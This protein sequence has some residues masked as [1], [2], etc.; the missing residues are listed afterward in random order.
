MVGLP[1][2]LVQK[3]PPRQPPSTSAASEIVGSGRLMLAGSD[4][5]GRKGAEKAGVGR[6]LA[7]GGGAHFQARCTASQ[8]NDG[9]SPEKP[10]HLSGRQ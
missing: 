8:V 3:I 10:Y 4:F 9:P 1:R 2:G 7:L 6:T 5:C